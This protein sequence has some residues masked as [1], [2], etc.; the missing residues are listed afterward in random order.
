MFTSWDQ[1]Q[2]WIED[3]NFARWI[4]YKNNPEGREDKATDIII[5]SKNFTV[6]DFHDKL[7]MTEKYIRMY[8]AK[9]YGV[10]YQSPEGTRNGVYCEVRL[11]EE[12]PQGAAGIGGSWQEQ[13]GAMRE[14]ITREIRAEMEA[15]RYKDERE[16]F[17]REKKE[18]EEEKKS[19]MGALTHYL[20]PLGQMILQKKMGMPMVAGVDANE[21]VH[22]Q[23][24]I[25]DRK[26]ADAPEGDPATQ[27]LVDEANN[28]T[29]EEEEK[30]FDLLSRFKKVE[31]QYLQLIEAVVTMA[32]NG[33]STYTMAKGFLIK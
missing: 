3:N 32:E 18:F 16:A 11:Q 14:S 26:P 6:S 20:A 19:A 23:P 17:E 25:P 31:P 12:Q 10:G 29:D 28:F 7:A 9:V 30:L 24:I 2:S 15:Q 27:E 1:V 33:D 5:D 13:I 22:A 4:F 8:G 21:P